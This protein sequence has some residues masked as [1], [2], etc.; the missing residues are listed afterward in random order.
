MGDLDADN[1]SEIIVV[2]AADA[3]LSTADDAFYII[4]GGRY[5]G[6]QQLATTATA[7]IDGE[8]ITMAVTL[9]D[10]D[11]DG[12]SDLLLGE[13]LHSSEDSGDTGYPGRVS[14]LEAPDALTDGD[15]GSLAYGYWAGA[16]AQ[17]LGF[18]GAAGDF[19]G[20]AVGDVAVGALGESTMA[21][22]AGAVFVFAPANAPAAGASAD[23]AVVYGATDDGYLGYTMKNAG[24]VD[25]DG[26]DDLLVSE[27]QAEGT[28]GRVWLLSGS[29]TLTS[30]TLE[31]SAILAWGGELAGSYTGNALAVGDLDDDGVNDFVIGAYGYISDG[32][33]SDANGRVYIELSGR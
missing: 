10:E 26:A 13:S 23:G 20:D 8:G 28:D 1:A 16:G 5:S 9:P 27:V 14:V 32:T 31:D 15:L 6:T 4:G 22:Y 30:T 21:Q 12:N 11:G 17:Q 24:D 33:T 2:N 19:D 3:N 7:V 29:G 18:S 25:G